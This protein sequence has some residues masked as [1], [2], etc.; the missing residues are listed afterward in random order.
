MP[1]EMMGGRMTQVGGE[2]TA[3]DNNLF[4]RALE[5]IKKASLDKYGYRMSD[6]EAR[7][8]A[9]GQ[10][11]KVNI[12]KKTMDSVDRDLRNEIA[13]S[14]VTGMFRGEQTQES[15][16]LV[17]QYTG[18][19]EDKITPEGSHWAAKTA[20]VKAETR[21]S[22]VHELGF[23]PATG[24]LT[25]DQQKLDWKINIEG[26]EMDF[27]EAQDRFNEAMLK[28]QETGIWE[29][30]DGNKVHTL[31]KQ[32]QDSNIA[33]ETR[34][35]NQEAWEASG[36]MRIP[37]SIKAL[38]FGVDVE[39]YFNRE[40]GRITDTQLHAQA[41][42][43]I[44]EAVTNIFGE[45]RLTD[46]HIHMLVFGQTLDDILVK[47]ADAQQKAI[48]QSFTK[49]HITGELDG[50]KTL[51]NLK[52][53][54]EKD[55][56][57]WEQAD[58]RA[59]Q[60]GDW[61]DPGTEESSK[62]LQ[63]KILQLQVY[64]Q[65]GF[66][67]DGSPT[68]ARH[69]SQLS[70]D[71]QVDKIFGFDKEVRNPVTGHMEW[72]HIYGTNE[73]QLVTQTRDQ[74]FLE[75]LET[76]FMFVGEDGAN[77][78][79][80]G[81]TEQQKE[82]NA[83]GWMLDEKTRNGYYERD[84]VTG[85]MSLV[86]GTQGFDRWKELLQDRYM[87]DGQDAEDARQLA[88][89]EHDRMQ[90]E[91]YR[92]VL[93]DE[94][95]NPVIDPRTGKPQTRWVHGKMGLEQQHM[96]LQKTLHTLGYRAEA[97]QRIAAQ[98]YEDKIREGYTT[99][100]D[101]TG[102]EIHI[103]GTQEWEERR[104]EQVQEIDDAK[105]FGRWATSEAGH[106][107]FIEGTQGFEA[108]MERER[109][110]LVK[111]GWKEE[112]IQAK[113]DF[114]R[115][116]QA[117]WGHYIV[118]PSNPDGLPLYIEGTITREW[119][120]QLKYLE[121]QQDGEEA[122]VRVRALLVEQSAA[123]QRSWQFL[124]NA[125][126]RAG[127]LDRQQRDHAHN[128][129]QDRL[130]RENQVT[131]ANIVADAAAARLNDEQDWQLTKNEIDRKQRNRDAWSTVLGNV[132]QIP[133]QRLMYDLAWGDDKPESMKL[134]TIGEMLDPKWWR[135][136]FG[137]DKVSEETS[138][139]FAAAAMKA[140]VKTVPENEILDSQELR[141]VSQLPENEFSVN[142]EPVGDGDGSSVMGQTPENVDT[143]G[144]EGMFREGV[145][146]TKTQ[147]LGAIVTGYAAYRQGGATEQYLSGTPASVAWLKDMA[148]MGAAFLAGGWLGGLAYGL[149]RFFAHALDGDELKKYHEDRGTFLF[150]R[151]FKQRMAP[152]K[153][154][155]HKPSSHALATM[156]VHLK[157]A[158]INDRGW[159]TEGTVE[160]RDAH[161]GQLH[162]ESL[163]EFM[164]RNDVS[165][166]PIEYHMM[167]DWV[168]ASPELDFELD[169]EPRYLWIMGA[170]N[171]NNTVL[172]IMGTSGKDGEHP[173]MI[174]MSWDG[175]N[176]HQV[177]GGTLYGVGELEGYALKD[178][179]YMRQFLDAFIETDQSADA[180]PDPQEDLSI[181]EQ[182][183][184]ASS[185]IDSEQWDLLTSR[186]SGESKKQLYTKIRDGVE[187][188]D[189][190][191][192]NWFGYLDGQ[193]PTGSELL[194]NYYTLVNLVEKGVIKRKGRASPSGRPTGAY[195]AGY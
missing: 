181:L 64:D 69:F 184:R 148:G 27:K 76:G 90:W 81:R 50:V 65:S 187:I 127:A 5:K 57:E 41:V 138:E 152:I 155:K 114:D 44:R 73:L 87:R 68:A 172:T 136:R 83:Q 163:P 10:T 62:T 166:M 51:N 156:Q 67:E 92:A 116:H 38:D 119:T 160:Y 193:T 18:Y 33:M 21:R 129:E 170:E 101:T 63:S 117:E 109:A 104:L 108:R 142:V 91:G 61:I 134:P 34:L 52:L 70:H 150:G 123:K 168:K 13:Q 75:K 145:M 100:D 77:H 169:F 94:N 176:P 39:T 78:W 95:G 173:G 54:L 32:L 17:A 149:G 71:L 74:D 9:S 53:D 146:P 82:L 188:V 151:A 158:S 24:L 29:D 98:A 191:L 159:R 113:E 99:T 35:A 1:F 25:V 174:S 103:W 144:S 28:G 162:K 3:I 189:D 177:E 194:I 46:R 137:R 118:D 175:T 132:V 125:F 154:F 122:L 72:V 85:T 135:E 130:D 15:K 112:R 115:K 22:W 12:R 6:E 4:G 124:E 86:I 143:G 182:E 31:K 19:W 2:G 49:A 186:L 58:M 139:V 42:V 141:R 179:P 153:D 161:G 165:V 111:D 96:N 55:L 7:K 105:R 147:V 8:I 121:N 79:W 133:L 43:D 80:G 180:L 30:E 37:G 195:P 40:S 120:H 102:E 131:I 178:D 56:F 97:A 23:D 88:E 14:G 59:R 110:E 106:R 190:D 126:E 171:V 11:S 36:V 128:Q 192:Y 164:K 66:L 183:A 16:A 157:W 93:T 26:Q 47:T 45:D 20:A 60:T 48:E 140:A 185:G 84:S 89:F 167:E 107:Y